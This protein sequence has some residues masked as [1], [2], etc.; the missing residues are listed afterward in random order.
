M[1][2][3]VHPHSQDPDRTSDGEET[4]ATEP[5]T[6]PFSASAENGYRPTPRVSVPNPYTTRSVDVDDVDTGANPVGQWRG[7]GLHEPEPRSPH[8]PATTD[9][10]T[11]TPTPPEHTERP[12]APVSPTASTAPDPAPR[13]RS[14]PGQDAV[15]E[16]RR[17]EA[18][19]PE[20][21]QPEP[22]WPA[23]EPAA[24][25]RQWTPPQGDH[26]HQGYEERPQAPYEPPRTSPDAPRGAERGR[27]T[28]PAYGHAPQGP[29]P[30]NGYREPQGHPD[31]YGYQGHP[32]Y[33]EPQ[34][35]QGY[36]G[37]QGQYGH[38]GQPAA[39]QPPHGYQWPYQEGHAPPAPHPGYPR[40]DHPVP[41]QP[42]PHYPAPYPPHPQPLP[43]QS[44]YP[45]PYQPP[46]YVY[47]GQPVVY[48]GQFAPYGQFNP[49]GQPVQHVIVLTAGQQPQIVSA[50]SAATL[51]AE[52]AEPSPPREVGQDK[53]LPRSEAETEAAEDQD[54][55]REEGPAEQADGSDR[56][57]AEAKPESASRAGAAD[58]AA[59]DGAAASRTASTADAAA[60]ESPNDSSGDLLNEA[61]AGLAMRD[62]SLVDALLEM[63]EALE[64][65]AQ[66][67]DLLDKLFQIDNFA[68]RMRRN[69]E[70]F[71]VLTGHDGGESD[72]HDEIVP[73][74]D[75][76]RAAT[77]EIKDYPRVSLGK[78]PQTSITGLAADDISHLL[79]ELLDNAT[80][81]S[82]EHS[83]VVISAQ[84]L[85]DGRLMV[86][87][88]DEGVGIPET[89]LAE[90]NSR[91]DGEPVLDDE[92]PRHM[93][94]YVASRIA[95]KHGLETRLESRSFRG[96]SAYTIVPKG[97]LRVATP[98]Q[99]GQ[100][101]TSTIPSVSAPVTPTGPIPQQPVN[102]K[103]GN[104]SNGAKPAS[105]ASGNSSV[106]S[107][108]LPRRS[109]TPH[110]SPLRMMP[111]PGA[112]SDNPPPPPKGREDT[113]PKLTGEARAEQIRDELGDFLDGERAALD[114]EDLGD[115]KE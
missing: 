25:Q 65:D 53:A 31:Q 88:E 68:T 2:Q 77:S 60:A 22:Q 97:L 102:G 109:A 101:R 16:P 33:P 17:P 29:Q 54:R 45:P 111:H 81:N 75:V 61:L 34:G 104:G 80:A 18:R 1:H 82:P 91:L 7:V 28:G 42:A 23:A 71:L 76:A 40:A 105:S 74:L 39:P 106:T 58:P 49:Y 78:L 87:V 89:Q 26:A 35:Q 19:Q 47:P 27:N 83:Q 90:L 85:E 103:G 52:R 5:P 37:Y 32:G 8:I 67:P 38:Q 110:G 21:Q 13:Q 10:M 48:P 44:A 55:A 69:G 36:Q 113:P 9:T 56:N 57:G 108:G 94:L 100:T 86:V 73:L 11:D 41:P 112:L 51:F 93:G 62:L 98:R 72:A 20:P 6:G 14:A 12:E 64:T 63:V 15:R 84:E 96:V 30:H 115:D 114:G 50:E 43:Y 3:P 107:A 46:G 95:Q 79:A 66:D 99:P 24:P 59:E 70:N 4:S 92:V